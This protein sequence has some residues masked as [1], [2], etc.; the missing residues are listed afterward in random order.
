[1]VRLAVPYPR[2]RQA[3]FPNPHEKAL[4]RQKMFFPEQSPQVIVNIPPC[5]FRLSS[6]VLFFS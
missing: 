5:E 2:I 3:S 6:E 1:M 4:W